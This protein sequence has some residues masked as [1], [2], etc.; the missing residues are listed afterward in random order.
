VLASLIISTA[1]SIPDYNNYSTNFLV[2]H[3]PF[4]SIAFQAYFDNFS[5]KEFNIALV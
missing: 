5:E 3:S 1:L 4:E 2:Y